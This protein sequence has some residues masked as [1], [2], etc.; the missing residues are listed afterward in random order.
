MVTIRQFLIRRCHRSVSGTILFLMVAGI[1]VS[2]GPRL[3][4]FRFVLAVLMAAVV[5]AAFW[6]LFKILC[7]QCH[8]PMGRVGFWVAH[9]LMQESSPHCPHCN[10]SVDTE[11]PRG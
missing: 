7:P 2:S 9:G 1:L 10:V 4:V 3:F 6:S 5:A 11:I 8:Q